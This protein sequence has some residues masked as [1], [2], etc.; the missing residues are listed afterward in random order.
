MGKANDPDLFSDLILA[1]LR[2]HADGWVT[3]LKNFPLPTLKSIYLYPTPPHP[4]PFPDK[5]F[6]VLFDFE[7][8]ENPTDEQKDAFHQFRQYLVNPAYQPA[9]IRHLNKVYKS[10]P[11]DGYLTKE[12]HFSLGL[13][14]DLKPE[15]WLVGLSI[16]YCWVLYE[17]KSAIL[18][19]N[20]SKPQQRWDIAY[21]VITIL[22][23]NGLTWKKIRE[24]TEVSR[25]WG[26]SPPTAEQMIRVYN[27]MV[28]SKK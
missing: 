8:I 21:P 7:L 14:V 4:F 19:A 22:R 16:E 17:N 20:K 10:P 2:G 6:L 24:H 11:V 3:F 18:I 27:R 15:P 1:T 28:R 25:I 5:Q 12:W 9:M 13:R 23:A 26:G